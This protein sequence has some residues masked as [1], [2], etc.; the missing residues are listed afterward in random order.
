MINKINKKKLKKVINS[1]M[2][3]GMFV[4]LFSVSRPAFAVASGV[5]K[6]T[7][8][9]IS[10]QPDIDDN[11]LDINIS[12]NAGSMK[13]ESTLQILIMLT[14]LSLAPSIL[15]MVTSFTRIVVVFHFLRTALGTQTTPPNQVI[16]GL[17]LFITIAIMSP[18]FT[19][20]NTKA[21]KPYTAG[22][23]KQEQAIEK[24]L[25]PLREFMLKQTREK[26][27]K[28]FMDLNKKSAD[29]IKD[30]D[31]IPIT[32]VIPAFIISEL[33]AAFIIGFLIYLPFIVIDMVV[34]ST[35]MSMGMM[36]LPPTTISLPFKLLLFVLAD[37]WNLVIG[38]LVNSFN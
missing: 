24:G 12:S 26:D 13:L 32:I 23:I 11:T 7:Q 36:M 35:L 25:S 18:V 3:I 27:L 6:T 8:D 1:L 19:E 28:L 29:D 30:Y 21:I 5:D 14:I 38:Q 20:V 15:I 16:V 9:E 34:A 33:R 4:L 17:A 37:G 31:D 22:K 2:I 10:G